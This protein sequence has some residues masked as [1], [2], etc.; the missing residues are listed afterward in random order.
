[1]MKQL[2]SLDGS[3]SLFDITWAMEWKFILLT[4]QINDTKISV[5]IQTDNKQWIEAQA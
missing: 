1:M 5:L 3:N 4:R 2:L